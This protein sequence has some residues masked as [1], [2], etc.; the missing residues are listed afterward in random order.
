M[1]LFFRVLERSCQGESSKTVIALDGIGRKKSVKSARSGPLPSYPSII[2]LYKTT[3]LSSK[4]SLFKREK[5]RKE[6]R[7]MS[8]INDNH[9]RGSKQHCFTALVDNVRVLFV[10][11]LAAFLPF[12]Y[13]FCRNPQLLT[14]NEFSGR[15]SSS[16]ALFAIPSRGTS[17]TARESAVHVEWEPVPELQ[18]RIEDGIHYEHWRDDETH[19]RGRVE[20]WGDDEGEIEAS[21]PGVFFGYRATPEDYVRLKSAD[22]NETGDEYDI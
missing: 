11:S 21:L 7:I 6:S 18:R 4:A 22:P 19:S 10:L 15:A 16:M 12:A 9:K 14:Q 3:I 17:S 1:S 2:Q 20:S 5:A 8:R 13:S